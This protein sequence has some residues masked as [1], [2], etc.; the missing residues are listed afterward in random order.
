[1]FYSVEAVCL[2]I[3]VQ[4]SEWYFYGISIGTI[5]YR[6]IFFLSESS[7]AACECAVVRV[8]AAMV[9]AGLVHGCFLQDNSAGC[10]SQRPELSALGGAVGP[11]KP[12]HTQPLTQQ[13]QRAAHTTILSGD[14]LHQVQYNKK[15]GWPA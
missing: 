4:M 1:M 9:G 13:N 7:S 6:L 10:V 5:E 11:H 3:C 15:Q 8:K 2:C 12:A 14:N